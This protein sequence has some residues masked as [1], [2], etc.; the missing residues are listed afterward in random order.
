MS[1]LTVSD[2]PSD[3]D[4]SLGSERSDSRLRG[5]NSVGGNSGGDGA[6]LYVTGFPW[7]ESEVNVKNFLLD[8]IPNAESV[9]VPTNRDGK[10]KGVAFIQLSP[11]V[12]AYNVLNQVKGLEMGY[13]KL[14]INKFEKEE[15]KNFAVYIPH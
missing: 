6:T 14:T 1:I 9:R 13:L 4:E 15:G 7:A 10:I 11:G 12:N 8:K 5:R 2:Q 3:G